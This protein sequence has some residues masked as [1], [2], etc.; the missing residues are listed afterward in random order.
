[1][2]EIKNSSAGMADAYW[3][4]WYVGLS[5]ALDMLN[6][7]TNIESVILQHTHLQGLDDVVVKYRDG[8]ATCIQIKHT[9][10]G[11]KIS[12]S[13]LI[14]KTER[15]NSLLYRSAE[16]WARAKG[17]YRECEAVLYT[18][19][20]AGLEFEV[21][22]K[23]N[24]DGY[25]RPDLKEFYS[26][27]KGEIRNISNLEEFEKLHPTWKEAWKE[28]CA[29]LTCLNSDKEK[30][31]FLKSLIIKTEQKDLNE[32]IEEVVTK[33]Q[34]SFDIKYEIACKLDMKLCLALRT[35]TTD[36]R[37]K[38]EITK[39][40]L[41]QALSIADD[42][43]VG[44]HDI[45]V[46][47]PVF[48]SRIKFSEELENIVRRREK[49]VVFLYGEPGCGK[50][51][52]VSNLVQKSNSVVSLRF[53]AFK[54]LTVEDTYLSPDGGIYD[55]KS[56]WGNLLIGLR[57]Q[58]FGKLSNYNVPPVNDFLDTIDKLR[59]KVLDLASAL[60]KES[61]SITVIAIDG[62]DHA[63]RSGNNNSFLKTLPLPEIIPEN[64]CFLISGQMLSYTEYYPDWLTDD[65]RVK[66]CKVPPI[67]QEDIEQIYDCRI[68]KI[69]IENRMEAIRLIENKC[70]GNT[71]VAIFATYEAERCTSISELEKIIH[72]KKLSAG[73][74]EYYEYIWKNAIKNIPGE[75]V[76]L[77]DI[78]AGVLALLNKQITSE[79]LVQICNESSINIYVWESVLEALFP[80]IISD[81]KEYL[82]YH[83]DIRIYL[84][85]KIKKNVKRYQQSNEMIADYLYNRCDDIKLKH[86]N[87]FQF[88]LNAQK[89]RQYSKI[90]SYQYVYE[91]IKYKRPW[92]EIME[93]LN[94]TLISMHEDVEFED[95]LELSCSVS[96]IYQY[97][98]SLQWIQSKHIEEENLP[99]ILESERKV[100]KNKQFAV[101]NIT[102]ML[103]DIIHLLKFNELN[104]ANSIYDRWLG[105]SNPEQLFGFLKENELEDLQESFI[106]NIKNVMELLGFV[107]R[108][109]GV[110]FE[111]ERKRDLL[112]EDKIVRSNFIKGWLYAA[113]SFLDKDDIKETLS[114]VYKVNCFLVQ[115]FQEF[116]CKLIDNNKS[117]STD[118]IE[119]RISSKFSGSTKIKYLIWTAIKNEK[120]PELWITDIKEKPLGYWIEKHLFLR[121]KM[122]TLCKLSF[123]FKYFKC[124]SI[125]RKDIIKFAYDERNVDS[126]ELIVFNIILDKY[127]YL[128]EICSMINLQNGQCDQQK[129][130]KLVRDTFDDTVKKSKLYNLEVEEFALELII[131]LIDKL[132]KEYD[133]IL[134]K[135]CF[136]IVK[137]NKLT[138][139][140]LYWPYLMKHQCGSL[141]EELYDSWMSQQGKVWNEDLDTMN[142]I[143]KDF[144]QKAKEIGWNKKAKKAEELL[145]NKLVGYTG[146]K[147]YSLGILNQWY[148][149]LQKIDIEGLDKIGVE[150]LNISSWVSGVADNRVDNNIETLVAETAGRN[151]YQA[152]WEFATLTCKWNKDWIRKIYD[153][154]I[155]ALEMQKFTEV[156]LMNIWDST[157]VLLP[158]HPV[159]KNIRLG[160]EADNDLNHIYVCDVRDAII[161][162]SKRL[163][164]VDI[165]VGMQDLLPSS[166]VLNTDHIMY[167]Y[168]YPTRWFGRR[169]I[170]Y[171]KFLSRGNI[172]NRVKSYEDIFNDYQEKINEAD[173]I[174]SVSMDMS[175]LAVKFGEDAESTVTVYIPQVIKYLLNRKEEW[176]WNE[177]STC[178]VLDIIF[179]FLDMGTL[180]L[181]LN[182]VIDNYLNGEEHV[183]GVLLYRLYNNLENFSLYY[184][185]RL[186]KNKKIDQFEKLLH[187]HKDWITGFSTIPFKSNYIN[188]SENE[189]QIKDWRTLILEIVRVV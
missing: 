150:L 35:W 129:F 22:A 4:E 53:Y 176:A 12:F 77:Q 165:E 13:D 166:Y 41:Y 82:A 75:Y 81:E 91:A 142:S 116:F 161:L 50:T 95:V 67:I 2:A 145:S 101:D 6:I 90:F 162:A 94:N 104:R 120:I 43:L 139:I 37:S 170:G 175:A 138:H 3:Y 149:R 110:K 133:E 8:A 171:D 173:E 69:P 147:E 184:S 106:E 180:Q 60:A 146:H 26:A 85:K 121:E 124:N 189:I 17:L 174:Y 188:G 160:D 25:I 70:E 64:V 92:K 7:D 15:K 49:P 1:M 100:L 167:D 163:E 20:E 88:F 114:I 30:I 76:Y 103:Y 134:L 169:E 73:I 89:E 153:G 143:A 164:I 66:Q 96:T 55:A 148:E 155:A 119:Q 78:L 127:E 159:I 46:Q 102:N 128:S 48:Q 144:I 56:L 135:S 172:E 118:I 123:L 141:L 74:N 113:T 105:N 72:D 122:L 97:V 18:N 31:N 42:E 40:V 154:I 185:D 130:K 11:E 33:L 51:N 107:C 57:K 23:D 183:E 61:G 39:E 47:L 28:W 58:L 80:I 27:L 109:I 179:K 32:I 5:N 59:E 14:Y 71:L 44:M 65:N 108:H 45:P 16:D 19:R 181:L 182:K 87:I 115:D 68:T 112:I 34:K 178:K 36:L 168:I 177:D 52:I 79:E 117:I 83:N 132:P 111:L 140:N 125:T 29:Q 10:T 137:S 38:Q 186:H 126:D 54:P 21:K 99:H 187:M 63:V 86:E 152:L 157:A 84:E 131:Q 158:T 98:Q 93:Q 9:K 151:G 136:E 156:D 24:I 62:I